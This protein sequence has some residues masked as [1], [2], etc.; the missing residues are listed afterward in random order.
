MSACLGSHQCVALSFNV[1][2]FLS[3]R[4]LKH[5][6][7]KGSRVPTKVC[8]GAFSQAAY[9]HVLFFSFRLGM[10]SINFCLFF[11]SLKDKIS[12]TLFSGRYDVCVQSTSAA[13][14]ALIRKLERST[15]GRGLSFCYQWLPG[16][17]VHHLICSS[18][19]FIGSHLAVNENQ[20]TP[21]SF[22]LVVF[23]LERSSLGI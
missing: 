8:T 6:N 20:T 4:K 19:S 7:Q 9:I 13:L 22:P 21:E 3:P 2:P 11:V 14:P 23:D 10:H 16:C 15:N 17:F 1:T 12:N 18:V 5:N